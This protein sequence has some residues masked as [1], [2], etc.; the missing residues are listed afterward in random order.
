ME[1]VEAAQAS[2]ERKGATTRRSGFETP[3]QLV[4]ALIAAHLLTAPSLRLSKREINGLREQI[5]RAA[6]DHPVVKRYMAERSLADE[7]RAQG[8][9]SG[10]RNTEPWTAIGERGFATALLAIADADPEVTMPLNEVWPPASICMATLALSSVPYLWMGE[11]DMARAV[12]SVPACRLHDQDHRSERP[13]A[14]APGDRRDPAH[15][16]RALED[17]GI[18]RRRHDAE[19]PMT[20]SGRNY[21]SDRPTEMRRDLLGSWEG[22]RDEV[23]EADDKVGGDPVRRVLAQPGTSKSSPTPFERRQ[24]VRDN[25]HSDRSG[26]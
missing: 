7:K 14:A 22:F 9:G 8:K 1:S 4:D 23:G 16:G 2:I 3:T 15:L 6:M 21:S 25:S 13:R 12:G 19:P 11:V 18:T 17:R 24:M 26:S 10:Y 5:R 20:D